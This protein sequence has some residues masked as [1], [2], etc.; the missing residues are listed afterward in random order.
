MNIFS[1]VASCQFKNGGVDGGLTMR[2]GKSATEEECAMLVKQNRPKAKGAI[3]FV[4]SQACFA[5]SGNKLNKK[6]GRRTCFFDGK[7]YCKEWCLV[8]NN[9]LFIIFCVSRTHQHCKRR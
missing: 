4:F 2:V 8:K 6:P 1:E 9:L 3:Y 7:L 5:T